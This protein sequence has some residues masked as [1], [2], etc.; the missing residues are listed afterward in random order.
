MFS[1]RNFLSNY[2]PLIAMGT[3][4]L[5]MFVMATCIGLSVNFTA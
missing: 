1:T 2:S 4:I 3:A 5:G